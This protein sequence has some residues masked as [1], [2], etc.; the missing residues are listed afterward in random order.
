MKI[1][2]VIAHLIVFGYFV[3]YVYMTIHNLILLYTVE[4]VS[5]FTMLTLIDRFNCN[6]L[7][8]KKV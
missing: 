7:K 3:V 8:K 2:V 1:L 6:K 5:L 4:V